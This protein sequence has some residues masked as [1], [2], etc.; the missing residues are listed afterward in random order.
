MTTVSGPSPEGEP[1][2]PQEQPLPL[3]RKDLQLFR[4]PNEEDGSPTYNIYDPVRA[5]YFKIT[6]AESQIIRYLRPGMTLSE[7]CHRIERKS[8]LRVT[9]DDVK[10][11]FVQAQKLNL[12]D[13]PRATEQVIEEHQ[14][15]QI[16]PIKWLAMHYLYIR[17]PLINPDKFL[18]R[19]LKY[20]LYFASRPAMIFYFIVTLMGLSQLSFRFEEFLGT[21]PYFFNVKG[22]FIYAVGITGVKLIHEFSHAYTA[23]Y[24]KIHVPSMGVAFLVLWPVLYTDVT[25]SWKLEKRRHRLAIS[26]AGV[27]S[28]LIIA[29]ICTFLWSISTPGLLQSVFFVLSSATWISTL[30]INLNPALRFDGYYLL[31]DIW[32]IDNLQSRCFAMTRWKYR[33][34]LFGLDLPPPEPNVSDRRLFGM[35]VYSIYTWIYRV[36]LYT[37]IA[38]FIYMTFT[39][40]LGIFLFV[41]EI[42]LFLVWPIYSEV[43]T[44][45][46]LKDSFKRNV[47]LLTTIFALSLVAAWAVFP[48]PRYA[49][50]SAI[51]VPEEQQLIYIPYD[52][53]V[54]RVFVEREDRVQKGDPIISLSS[55]ALEKE[56]KMLQAESEQLD[57]EIHVFSIQERE[58]AFIP[59]KMAQL[60][61]VNEQLKGLIAQHQKLTVQAELDGIVFL[62]DETIRE[63]QAVGKDRIIGKIAVLDLVEVEAFA[64]EDLVADLEV[65]QEVEFRLLSTSDVIKGKIKRIDPGRDTFLS[66]PQLASINQ[67]DLAVVPEEKEGLRLI[68]SYYPIRIELDP[69]EVELRFGMVGEVKVVTPPKSK[70]VELIKDIMSIIWRE[71]SI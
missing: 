23:K 70:F 6:W 13:L 48:M 26:G 37:A 3:M 2:Q 68:D 45:F 22:I 35:M 54:E 31:C 20:V 64:P 39:K 40:A 17:V 9:P 38:V 65:G 29:G 59:E 14:R 15:S 32:G 43:Q 46:Q 61:S 24:Y 69:N 52:S 12:L 58:R 21:F 41:L 50:F 66:H 36:F 1:E 7:L 11:F 18:D 30:A 8:T 27:V 44:L 34:M 4:G 63:K 10:M 16:N 62:W 28:E 33:K 47:R 71:S 25:D 67:G 53:E 60:D 49:Y 56:I 57:Q 42:V 19:T 51:T 55:E 5:Q